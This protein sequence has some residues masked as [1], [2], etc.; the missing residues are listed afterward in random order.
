MLISLFTQVSLINYLTA[1]QTVTWIPLINF[2]WITGRIT[3]MLGYPNN[4]AFGFALTIFPSLAAAS[5]TMYK[6]VTVH[7]G[8]KCW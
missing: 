4:R 5:F 6:F 7:Y 1:Q 3:Y 2:F 8:I